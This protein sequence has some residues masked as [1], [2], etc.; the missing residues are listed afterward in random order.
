MRACPQGWG[1][2]LDLENKVI[3]V[4]FN[5][6]IL[7]SHLAFSPEQGFFFFFFFFFGLFAFSRASPAAYGGS[8]ARG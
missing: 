4:S 7:K 8:R 5:L 6:L 1:T 3:V 2:L